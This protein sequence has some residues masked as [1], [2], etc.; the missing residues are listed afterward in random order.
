MTKTVFHGSIYTIVEVHCLMQFLAKTP[1]FPQDCYTSCMV[2]KDHV[3]LIEKGISKNGGGVW[4]DFGSGDG[5]FTLALR[6]IA[7][8][9]VQ[10][11]SL[12]Q[13][14]SRLSVQKKEFD[15]MFPHSH[16]EY[17]AADFTGHL[18]L[19]PLDG[20]IA[21]NSIHFFKERTEVIR[22]LATYLKPRGTFI[23][24]EY[25]ADQGNMWVPHPFTYPQ[26][27][28]FAN[29]AGLKNPQLLATTPSS[30]LDEIYSAKA[31][32]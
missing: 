3:R 14:K 24:V 8:P 13:E 30:F 21:A 20:L 5:A 27:A 10:I 11:F 1:C 6:D 29:Q 31:V 23:I 32:K 19:P 26:F 7:G 12:D 15:Q 25:N 4:A 2:H 22:K 18:D 17:I 28:D 9:D 16:I